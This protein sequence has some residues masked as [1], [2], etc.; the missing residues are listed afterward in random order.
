MF[1]LLC[2]GF[3]FCD[4]QESVVKLLSSLSFQYAEKQPEGVY[5]KKPIAVM[6]FIEEGEMA[7]QYNL[8]TVTEELIRKVIVNSTYFLL[9]E[10]KNLEFILK[11]IEFSL[12]DLASEQ[13]AIRVG[14]LTGAAYFIAGSVAE[15]GDSFLL[16]VR[17]IDVE[18]GVVI[19]ADSVYIPKTEFIEEALSPQYS[20]VFKYSL[21]LYALGGLDLVLAGAPEHMEESFMP[22]MLDMGAG[23]SYRPWTF[24]QI[25][26]SL[27]NTWGEWPFGEFDPTSPDYD[28]SGILTTYYG[29]IPADTSLPSYSLEYSQQYIDVQ[30]LFVINPVRQ[31]TLSFGGGGI[32]GMWRAMIKLNNFPIY[33]GPYSGGQPQTPGNTLLYVRED[34]VIDSGNGLLL[35]F[36]ATVKAEYYI[37]PRV[38]VFAVLNYK[39][40][41][42]LDPYRY[43]L[44][45]IFTGSGGSDY[46]IQAS[47]W[48]PDK[49]PYGDSLQMELDSIVINAGLA[50]S[51]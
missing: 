51:F 8:G 37:S 16:N 25:T 41:F 20:Y 18:T 15:T 31:L 2:A 48:I 50:F 23:A 35:G 28:N 11:E 46:F 1:V 26:A 45:G 6:P 36:A 43:Y 9:T 4:I 34:L 21:G 17:L 12:S 10:R 40:V 7:E 14:N 29:S 19:G 38:L 27:H 13:T 24:L 30:A 3:L 47:K 42:G 49:T 39:K 22:M 44:G 32:L 5:F 33:V